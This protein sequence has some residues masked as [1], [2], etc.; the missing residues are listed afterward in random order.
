MGH[1]RIDFFADLMVVAAIVG[2]AAALLVL[3]QH[4]HAIL[5]DP[6]SGRAFELAGALKAL[7][8]H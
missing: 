5:I 8:A 1:S 4:F 3:S 2:G 7:L 6:R